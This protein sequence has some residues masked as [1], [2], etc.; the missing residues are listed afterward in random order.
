MPR[1][2]GWSQPASVSDSS[3]AAA[4]RDDPLDRL[5]VS[6]PR[7]LAATAPTCPSAS[8]PRAESKEVDRAVSKLLNAA[9][10]SAAETVPVNPPFHGGK[11]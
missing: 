7:R 10:L 6:Q 9:R 3:R 2:R 1:D 8:A 5:L 11:R 4:G